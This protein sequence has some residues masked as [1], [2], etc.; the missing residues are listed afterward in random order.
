MQASTTH[1]HQERSRP[2][3]GWMDVCLDVIAKKRGMSEWRRKHVSCNRIIDEAKPST[4]PA[5]MII[6]K[7][8]Y[9]QKRKLMNYRTI[10]T[11]IYSLTP[12][13]GAI[14]HKEERIT[15]II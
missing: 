6:D 2:T 14:I 11:L 12:F 7:S 5:L 10:K 1:Q 4:S 13:W 9:L 8:T 3:K 15:Y